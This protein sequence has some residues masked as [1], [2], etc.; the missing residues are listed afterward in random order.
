M[1]ENQNILLVNPLENDTARRKDMYPSGALV[2]IGTMLDNRGHNVEVIHMGSDNIG[3]GEFEK[4][5][6][7][8]PY[9]DS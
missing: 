6:I 9:N 4:I 5:V 8:Y 7:D 1:A 3:L 2:L